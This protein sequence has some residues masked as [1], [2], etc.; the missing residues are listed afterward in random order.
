M[1]FRAAAVGAADL[2]TLRCLQFNAIAAI[3]DTGKA[4]HIRADAI[5]LDRAANSRG[6]L[7]F[8]AIVNV[9]AD[10]ISLRPPP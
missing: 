9:P 8:D 2:V 1:I 6:R 7:Q 10:Q 5:S 3:G 4:C